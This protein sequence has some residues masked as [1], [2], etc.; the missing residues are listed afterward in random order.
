M[1]H[2]IHDEKLLKEIAQDFQNILNLETAQKIA[3]L[4]IE[5]E[6]ENLCKKLNI[7]KPQLSKLLRIITLDNEV[8]LYEANM[9]E[10]L[11]NIKD[12]MVSF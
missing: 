6:K 9:I 8:I 11:L 1:L 7:K 5:N 2:N 12:R 4:D 3:K 10:A